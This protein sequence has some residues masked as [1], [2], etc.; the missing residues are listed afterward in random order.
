MEQELAAAR[1]LVKAAQ[2]SGVAL[3]G[4]DRLLKAITKTVL[5]SA[6]EEEISEHL[7][8]DKHALYGRNGGS[9]GNGSNSGNGGNSGNASRSKTVLTDASGR[10]RD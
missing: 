10:G 6:L 5:E 1:E 3:T 9:P 7:G 2:A 4:P 8:Y